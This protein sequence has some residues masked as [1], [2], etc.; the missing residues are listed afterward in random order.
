MPC[1]QG[2]SCVILRP[3][4]SG[5]LWPVGCSSRPCRPTAGAVLLTPRRCKTSCIR[6]GSKLRPWSLCSSCGTPKRQHFCHRRSLMIGNGV[7]SISLRGKGP[8]RTGP[9]RCTN[10]V[11]PDSWFG[12]AI[13]CTGV[14][15]SCLEPVV[16]LSDLIQGLVDT[17]VTSW[18]STV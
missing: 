11:G 1:K 17:Q 9:R 3:E 16:L 2:G 6:R 12:A 4:P 18:W 8:A 10:A 14:A 7:Q 13:C 5:A 15:L